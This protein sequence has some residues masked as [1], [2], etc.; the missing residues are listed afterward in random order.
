MNG[1]APLPASSVTPTGSGSLSDRLVEEIQRQIVVGEIQIGAHLRHE[2]LADQFGVSRTPVREALRIL[3]AQGVVEIQP[4]R[5]AR[6]RGPSPRAL[7]ELGLVRAELEGFAAQCAAE[8]ILD[9][10]LK[11]LHEAWMGYQE[12]IDSFVGLDSDART[13]ATGQRWVQANAE[14]HQVIW[15]ASG[16][17]HLETTLEDLSRR[18]P[19]NVSFAAYRDDSRLLR[20]NV[21][22]HQAIERAIAAHE[23]E[24][25]RAAMGTHVRHSSEALVQWYERRIVATDARV[26]SNQS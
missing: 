6:V 25:A 26:A 23:P 19:R 20:R 7:R 18:L 5:G 15:E 13:D 17:Q 11:R 14:F 22:E 8:R 16:N 10:Q 21:A 9:R 3:A 4:H 12:A 24:A 2:S 1:P